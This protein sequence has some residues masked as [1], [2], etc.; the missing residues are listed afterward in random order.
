MRDRAR[1][2]CVGLQASAVACFVKDKGG[3]TSS[4]R[5]YQVKVTASL[6][7]FGI[8]GQLYLPYKLLSGAGDR[9]KSDLKT[10]IQQK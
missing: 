4:A 7:A 5:Q 3:S 2:N 9:L 10:A 8:V 6:N 1:Q